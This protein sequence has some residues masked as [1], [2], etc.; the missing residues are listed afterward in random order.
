MTLA[1]RDTEGGRGNLARDRSVGSEMT[2]K[3]DLYGTST[4]TRQTV[5]STHHPLRRTAG[6]RTGE[7]SKAPGFSLR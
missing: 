3:R 6:A 1:A 7:E 5:E 4:V 2:M